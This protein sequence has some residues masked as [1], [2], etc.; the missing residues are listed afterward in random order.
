MNR[1]III[2]F[3]L[4][5][6]WGNK[7]NAQM[8]AAQPISW[9][10][11]RT[12]ELSIPRDSV[13]ALLKDYTLISQLSNGYVQ[14]MVNTDNVMPIS[15]ETTLQD[16]TKRQELLSQIDDQYRFLVYKIQEVSLPSGI[17]MAQFAIFTEELDDNLCQISWKVIVK[18]E[19]EAQE[20]YI[21]LLSKEISAYELGFKKYIGIQP[22]TIPA[23]RIK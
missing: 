4:L 17:E 7:G 20:R 1:I 16:G 11:D 5:V 13:W 8:A 14:S 3:F 15:R 12:F 6:F 22:N 9:N 2:I 23:T 21:E 18:G 19:K 10:I